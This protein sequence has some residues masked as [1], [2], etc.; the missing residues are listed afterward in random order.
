MWIRSL[1]LTV[2]AIH[3]LATPVTAADAN[4][5]DDD[6][7]I[8]DLLELT[9]ALDLHYLW[10]SGLS[11]IGHGAFQ[12]LDTLRELW[13]HDNQI[14]SLE[15][16]SF[17]GLSNLTQLLLHGNHISSIE[18][19]DFEGLI[20]LQTLDLSDN[21]INSIE[22]GV[23][24]GLD[25][26]ESL[27]LDGNQITSIESG[28]FDGL[29]S[30]LELDLRAN[31]ITRIENDDFEGLTQLQ[32]LNLSGN[33]ISSIGSNVFQGLANLQTLDLSDTR[34][35]GIEIGALRE[36]SN[37]RTLVLR[38]NEFA[39]L[40]LTGVGFDQLVLCPSSGSY[41]FCMDGNNVTTLVLD[42]ATLGQ[43]AFRAI[44][45]E[46]DF[47]TEAS[48]VGLTF[49]DAAPVSGMNRLLR[50]ATL[51]NVTVDP[52]FFAM[53]A[54]EFTAWDAEEGN[55]L[56]IV[57]PGDINHDGTVD[58]NE[59]NTGKNPNHTWQSRSK[60]EAQDRRDKEDNSDEYR[61]E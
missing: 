4:I 24:V 28:G 27:Y 30:L 54:D 33:Q 34:I 14:N 61:E 13:L 12:E 16:G 8:T 49:S 21:H 51:D 47:I 58:A 15:S 5:D 31:Q 48:L 17:I 52:N 40:D 43:V 56:T 39:T 35:S 59:H 7:Y 29:A 19:S 10:L 60:N 26:L 9:P 18:S 3:S 36:H 38:G 46:A 45:S 41:G 25:R 44:M 50:I 6:W 57:V 1:I 53:Y 32:T 55:T 2:A 11:N 20:N 22:N 37:L 23:F 42:D